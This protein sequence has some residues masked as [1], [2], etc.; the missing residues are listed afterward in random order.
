MY[1]YSTCKPLVW[2][3]TTSVVKHKVLCA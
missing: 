2:L 1:T 3:S